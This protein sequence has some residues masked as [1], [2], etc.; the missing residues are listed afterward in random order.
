MTH[1]GVLGIDKTGKSGLTAPSR[2]QCQTQL[3]LRMEP[4]K[5]RRWRILPSY[6]IEMNGR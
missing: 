6:H 3:H 4:L 2:S 5:K 1:V